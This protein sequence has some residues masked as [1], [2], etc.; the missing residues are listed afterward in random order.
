MSAIDVE[1]KIIELDAQMR[2]AA[3]KLDFEKAIELRD[4]LEA[5][6]AQLSGDKEQKAYERKK[7]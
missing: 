2:V 6:K 3:E 4:T 1:K 7:K 5:L